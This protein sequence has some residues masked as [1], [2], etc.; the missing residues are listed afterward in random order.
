MSI[1]PISNTKSV[2]LSSSARAAGL[3]N[4]DTAE[5]MT[6]GEY[7]KYV[8]NKITNIQNEHF[9]GK[10]LAAVSIS[11]DGF[12]A[13]KNNPDYE[14]WVFSQLENAFGNPADDLASYTVLRIGADRKDLQ[15]ETWM[16][17]KYNKKKLSEKI[18]EDYQRKCRL[19]KK[20]M[21]KN[22][23]YRQYQRVL[24]ENSIQKA[25]IESEHIQG[26]FDDV[27][28]AK[29]LN[30]VASYR[31]IM[32]SSAAP[33]AEI[34]TKTAANLDE[35]QQKPTTEDIKEEYAGSV[36]FNS[37]KRARQLAS[38]ETPEQIRILLSI[39]DVDLSECREGLSKGWC[40]K[41]EVAKVEAMIQKSKE[42]Q[43]K[44]SSSEPSKTTEVSDGTSFYLNMIM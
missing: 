34:T 7:K 28:N 29:N 38:A 32:N 10:D 26:N 44:L 14:N 1:S 17:E 20:L 2:Y 12:K 39:L 21:A 30:A 23:H 33:K 15:C 16:E 25:K 11:E 35:I 37:E 8:Y 42:K 22:E 6:M 41:N 3:K 24:I 5:S 40:D 43:S 13:M 19:R 31:A 36:R 9:N 27:P 4:T 18:E